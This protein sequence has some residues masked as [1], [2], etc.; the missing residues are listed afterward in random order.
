MNDQW[1]FEFKDWERAF[2]L[3]YRRKKQDAS[4]CLVIS[5]GSYTSGYWVERDAHADRCATVYRS[6]KAVKALE[7]RVRAARRSRVSLSVGG[8]IL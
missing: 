7:E 4:L 6:V 5:T 1:H 3:F 2:E 8:V